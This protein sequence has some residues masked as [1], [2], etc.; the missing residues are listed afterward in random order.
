MAPRYMVFPFE[1]IL[2]QIPFSLVWAVYVALNVT[3]CYMIGGSFL[4]TCLFTWLV[5][6]LILATMD[7]L[8]LVVVFVLFSLFARA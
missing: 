1:W 3:E 8:I 2:V 6:L 4:P 7:V 5:G